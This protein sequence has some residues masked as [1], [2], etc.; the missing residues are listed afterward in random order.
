MAIPTLITDLSTTEASNSPAGSTNPF[1]DL[2][3]YIRALSMFIASIRANTATNGWVSPYAA[4]ATTN[5]YTKAQ[6]VTPVVLTDGATITPDA[7]LSNHFTVTL[8]GNRTLANPTNLV[9]GVILNFKIKQDA[10]GSRTLAYG[11]KYKFPSGV[12]P[13][14]TV[15]AAATDY[16]SCQYFSDDD[17]LVCSMSTAIA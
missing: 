15:A 10:T 13:T 8:A 6:T 12:T 1:P 16:L 4:L 11:S 5:T 14:L 2:D 3:N 17:I 7:S 9:N